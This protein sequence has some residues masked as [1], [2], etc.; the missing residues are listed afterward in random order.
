MDDVDRRILM[1]IQKNVRCPISTL[2]EKANASSASI[3]RRLKRL[4]KDGIIK[5]E[6]AIID[7]EAAGFEITAVISLDLER[8][9]ID[10]VDAFKRRAKNEPQV[11]QCYCVAGGADFI[12]IVIAKNMKD[13]E[14]F[15]H[16][17]FFND[18]NV[19]KFQTSIVVSRV[20]TTTYVP[21][22]PTD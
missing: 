7:H 15:T 4:R 16:R 14:T 22:L 6:V 18:S 9:R 19:R 8:D 13:Y 11:Q 17:F 2:S 21:M 20:K 5:S 10:E 12:L 3:Q 1:E